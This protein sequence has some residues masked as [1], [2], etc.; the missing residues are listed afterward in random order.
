MLGLNKQL[1]QLGVNKQ[2]SQL[3]LTKQFSQ[4]GLY[5]L[6]Q[7]GTNAHFFVYFSGTPLLHSSVAL[8]KLGGW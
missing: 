3:G 5:K 2:L 1:F 8:E 7:F 4:L 6:Y